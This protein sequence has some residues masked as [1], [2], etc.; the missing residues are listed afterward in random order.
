MTK[1]FIADLKLLIRNRQ[2]IF[3][4]F[5]FPLIFTVIFGFFFSGNS[6]TAGTIGFIDNAHTALSE[7]LHKVMASQTIFNLTDETSVSNAQNNIKN[8]K[9]S[10]AVVVPAGF[11]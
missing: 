8:G 11:G 2:V 3:W 7:S 9:E 6:N 5:A 1:L 10:G 4:S